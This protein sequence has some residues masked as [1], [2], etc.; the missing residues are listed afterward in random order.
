MKGTSGGLRV[1]K[2]V[3]ALEVNRGFN[4][5]GKAVLDTADVIDQRIVRGALGEAVKRLGARSISSNSNVYAVQQSRPQQARPA[6]ARK[7]TARV[8]LLAVRHHRR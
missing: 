6:S 8:P 3:H 5:I 7:L 2:Y 1:S 4:R